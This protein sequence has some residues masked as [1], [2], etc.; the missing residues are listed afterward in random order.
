[1]KSKLLLAGVFF[2]SSSWAG[3]Q[4]ATLEETIQ[5]ISRVREALK[6]SAD[7][8]GECTP[9]QAA[10]CTF[11]NYCSELGKK[12]GDLY[13]YQDSE[14]RQIPNYPMVN[15]M[16]FA[17]YCAGKPFPQAAAQDPFVFVDQ[18]FDAQRA[19]GEEKL[20]QNRARMEKEYQRVEKLF[21]DA[22][23]KV[24]AVLNKRKTAQNS[25]QI[26]NAIRRIQA[27]KFQR[28]DLNQGYYGLA[29]AGCEAPNAAFSPD[30]QTITVCPQFLN[31]PD[32]SLFSTLSHELGHAI[33]TC[34]LAM[35]TTEKGTKFPEWMDVVHLNDGKVVNA[36]IPMNKNPFQSVISCLESPKSL[37]VQTPS[38]ES[39][40]AS[41]DKE[42]QS[43]R[44]E[45]RQ[46]Q[47]EM[48]GVELSEEEM[49]FS[50]ADEARYE[51]RKS[52]IRNHYEEFKHCSYLTTN[53]HMV[54][55]FADWVAS[56]ALAER[57][58]EIPEAAKAKEYAFASQAGFYGL[59]CDNVTQ[60]ADEKIK[61]AI[62]GRCQSLQTYR[63]TVEDSR[64]TEGLD[65]SHPDTGRRINTIYYAQPTIKKALGCKSTN[66][67]T[68]CQ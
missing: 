12:A 37:G 38:K 65:S 61:G 33:D 46:S 62:G 7:A 49:Q 35:D 16:N 68:E 17:E 60:A 53:G 34:A 58:S 2:L 29:E 15:V 20:K 23:N 66:N 14:G 3:A 54:E 11:Q 36:A 19:G 44:E 18:M 10:H 9:P 13:L 47:E 24:L 43:M 5:K 45:L 25:A 28:P 59:Y 26:E 41:V 42:I 27:V 56:Q 48:G 57:I 67:S 30:T 6:L 64:K 63:E 39:L 1:M 40:L 4:D 21:S 22:K 50:D 51:D 52:S 32:A 31:L 8:M 55:A